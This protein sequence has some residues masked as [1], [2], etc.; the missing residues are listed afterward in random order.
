MELFRAGITEYLILFL[1]SQNYSLVSATL[2]SMQHLTRSS[3]E[4][5][6][7]LQEAKILHLLMEKYNEQNDFLIAEIIY[8]LGDLLVMHPTP[9]MIETLSFLIRHPQFGRDSQGTQF[10]CSLI[11]SRVGRKS[12][13]FSQAIVDANVVPII[14][15]HLSQD[16]NCHFDMYRNVIYRVFV[17]SD[18]PLIVDFQIL[19]SFCRY[20]SSPKE[21][22]IDLICL[23]IGSII[24]NQ[25][26]DQNLLIESG[27]LSLLLNSRYSE[28][29]TNCLIDITHY[30]ILNQEPLLNHLIDHGLLQYL[31]TAVKRNI[32][33]SQHNFK[34]ILIDRLRVCIARLLEVNPQYQQI[35]TDLNTPLIS[36]KP[37]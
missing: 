27:L 8:V 11:I 9:D 21:D 19:S 2:V 16:Y 25:R 28:D 36:S 37:F 26:V 3:R 23:S 15:H 17:Q 32:G 31:S 29:I 6:H 14:M 1:L 18:A 33:K 7:R 10:V 20:L 13:K 34:M 12:K 5:F 4:L 24:S 22:D 35:M 30:C